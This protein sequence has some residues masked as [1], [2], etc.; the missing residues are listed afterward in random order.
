MTIHA[1]RGVED[2]L[3]RDALLYQWIERE[4]SSLFSL[5]GYEEIRIPIFEKAELFLHSLG[6]ET[7]VGKQMYIFKDKK[8][9]RLCLRP[10][11]T[12]PVIRAYLQHKLY[13]ELKKWKVYYM[14]SMFRYERPQAGRSR[15]FRQIGIEA[16]GEENPHLDVEVI[17]MGYQFLKR[18]KLSN[19]HLHLNSIG[20]RKCRPLYEEKLRDYLGKN[21]NSLCT[22]CQRRYRYN[23]LRV[24]DCKNERCQPVIKGA[25]RIEKYLCQNCQAHFNEVKKELNALGIEFRLNPHLVRGLDYYTRT[26]FEFTSTLLGGQDTLCAGGRYDELIEELGGPSIPAMGFAIG[27]ERILI[28]LSKQGEGIPSKSP[29]LIYIATIGRES[30]RIGY[31]LANLLRSK[32]IKAQLSLSERSLSSQLKF[33]NKRRIRWVIILGDEEIKKRKVI[34]KDMNS[35]S[36][37]ELGWEE[38][39]KFDEEFRSLKN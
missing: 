11:A 31:Q 32:G 16:I 17:E 14:G 39:E 13:R 20:C 26:I 29:S 35:G 1:P 25:P 3:P 33:A 21:I 28:A 34:L 22:T 9:R 5:Y 12:A 36:Q 23:I 7:D 4:A 24:L 38:L 6:E 2:I 18:V 8:G 27:V 15:E 19:F 30:W 10:E 37:Q